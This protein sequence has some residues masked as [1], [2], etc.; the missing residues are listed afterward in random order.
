[1]K[2]TVFVSMAILALASCTAKMEN[3]ITSENNEE[4]L[5]KKIQVNIADFVS[6]DDPATKATVTTGGDFAW[7]DT[8]V[9]G[10]WP[11]TVTSPQVAQQLAFKYTDGTGANATFGGS[12]WGLIC[13]ENHGYAAYYPY[14]GSCAGETAIPFTY[15]ANLN[16][17]KN[18]IEV[19]YPYL[20]MYG[21]SVTPTNAANATFSFY[22]LSALAKFIIKPDNET[23]KTFT[24]LTIST[25]TNVFTTTGTYN[26]SDATD[27]VA[28]EITPTTQTNTIAFSGSWY[29]SK[30]VYPN[31]TLW[32][33]MCPAN[34]AG[35]TLTFTLRDME[36]DTYT[37]TYDCSQN[38]VSGMQY[39]YVVEVE[40]QIIDP[41]S[42]AVL[43]T[44]EAVDLGHESI[45]FANMN[46][47]ATSIEDFG[48]YF[49]HGETGELRTPKGQ[50]SP[51]L[52]SEANY[53]EYVDVANLENP[54]DDAHDAA[55]QLWGGDW[56]M[57][58]YSEL[59]DFLNNSSKVDREWT[60]INGVQ[61]FKFTNKV[62][63]ANW[64]FMPVTG[65]Y[66][67]GKVSGS[68]R[69]LYRTK[70]R[71]SVNWGYNFNIWEPNLEYP[72]GRISGGCDATWWGMAIRPVK[73]KPAE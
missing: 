35:K 44:I 60:T 14:A 17:M 38:Q 73:N 51:L 59:V 46:L 3:I 49:A 11:K 2:K 34:L 72:E 68:S 9:I 63:P 13:D 42:S 54:L 25:T 41:Y 4:V 58:T 40:K 36:G 10:V 69:G 29:I 57:P 55:V 66:N 67:S 30:P 26:L 21:P 39:N 48:H 50:R 7:S 27:L 32:M 24:T 1:M 23:S 37:G 53:S 56:R 70:N 61:G 33:A 16:E 18:G 64:I 71:S 28:P 45:L 65:Y 8:D 31:I 20:Y 52:F 12:G 62:E 15:P 43:S 5:A 47:G 6:A 22:Q 19:V